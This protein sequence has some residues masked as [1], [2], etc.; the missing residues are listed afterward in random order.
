[1]FVDCFYPFIGL[2]AC[3]APESHP[4]NGSYSIH[5]MHYMI[6]KCSW[7]ALRSLVGALQGHYKGLQEMVKALT[8]LLEALK[9]GLKDVERHFESI[10]YNIMF[11]SLQYKFE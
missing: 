6:L 3:E 11:R 5:I 10:Q 9:N 1:M 4:F 2:K 8:R 7:E